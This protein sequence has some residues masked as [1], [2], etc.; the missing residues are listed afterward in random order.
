LAPKTLSTLASSSRASSPSASGSLKVT[1]ARESIRWRSRGSGRLA[2]GDFGSQCEKVRSVRRYVR[3]V[4]T[5]TDRSPVVRLPRA[6]L[7]RCCRLM[8]GRWTAAE[9][10]I[11]KHWR[12]PKLHMK[13]CGVE[14]QAV[15]RGRN[16]ARACDTGSRAAVVEWAGSALVSRDGG[17]GS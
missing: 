13:R 6:H 12:T 8:F 1:E 11:A 4:S 15:G 16:V 5:V 17:R 14:R 9:G 7:G 3:R 10:K 2:W